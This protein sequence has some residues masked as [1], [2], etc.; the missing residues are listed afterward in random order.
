MGKKSKEKTPSKKAFQSLFVKDEVEFKKKTLPTEVIEKLLNTKRQFGYYRNYGIFHSDGP[1]STKSYAI[2]TD[3]ALLRIDFDSLRSRFYELLTPSLL[4]SNGE[5]SDIG[6]A[7]I[8]INLLTTCLKERSE[9]LISLT[10]ASFLLSFLDGLKMKHL[11]EISQIKVIINEMHH[12][13]EEN[14]PYAFFNPVLTPLI[15]E[16]DSIHSEINV[17]KLFDESQHL[18]EDRRIEESLSLLK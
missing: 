17:Y 1:S 13:V 2:K 7:Q 8:N 11:H 16:L 6:R 3:L 10:N 12:Y 9:K 5:S 15:S 14:N 18:E 4:N